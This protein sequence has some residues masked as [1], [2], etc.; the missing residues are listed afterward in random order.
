M[1]PAPGKKNLIT[2]ISGIQVGHAEDIQIALRASDGTARL[3]EN[4]EYSFGL[5]SNDSVAQITLLSDFSGVVDLI[6]NY[7]ATSNVVRYFGGEQVSL[8]PLGSTGA[9]FIEAVRDPAG[10]FDPSDHQPA[11]GWS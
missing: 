1:R 3:L 4:T 11:W 6:V 9:D 10:R 5:S 7:T 2:D 8:V